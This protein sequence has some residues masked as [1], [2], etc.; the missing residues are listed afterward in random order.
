MFVR[1]PEELIPQKACLKKSAICERINQYNIHRRHTIKTV[2]AH[3]L[4]HILGIILT[5]I[6]VEICKGTYKDPI[7]EWLNSDIFI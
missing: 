4:C 1:F 3:A 5:E 7:Q 6:Q 2:N